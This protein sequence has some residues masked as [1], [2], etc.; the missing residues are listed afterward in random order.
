ML[1]RYHRKFLKTILQILYSTPPSSSCKENKSQINWSH[2]SVK[3]IYDRLWEQRRIIDF[4]LNNKRHITIPKPSRDS[5]NKQPHERGRRNMILQGDCKM[6]SIQ[7]LVA[8]VK[9]ATWPHDLAA[10]H[11]AR[12][13][14]IN[15][16]QFPRSWDS[17]RQQKQSSLMC[18]FF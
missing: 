2:T 13:L 14:T 17:N 9:L 6:L 1:S 11:D 16:T 4:D 5:I 15:E 8:P 3:K 18:F 12:L 7:Q 10:A